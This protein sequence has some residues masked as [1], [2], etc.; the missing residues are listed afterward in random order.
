MGRVEGLLID[1]G[2]NV[3]AA[4]ILFEGPKAIRLDAIHSFGRRAVMVDPKKMRDAKDNRSLVEQFQTNGSIEGKK[5]VT[6]KG[7]ELG[8]VED[9]VFDCFSGELQ[10]VVV[11]GGVFDTLVHGKAFLAA[12]F[13]QSIGPDCVIAKGDAAEGII[14]EHGGAERLLTKV[15][16]KCKRIMGKTN[17]D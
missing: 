12:A 16:G 9:V 4:A 2:H 10:F 1:P 17:A 13:I 14:S 11:S 7:E 8:T 3:V 5:V 6:R 15:L